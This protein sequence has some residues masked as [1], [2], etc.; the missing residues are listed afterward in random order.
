LA[1][2]AAASCSPIVGVANG[3]TEKLAAAQQD[4]SLCDGQRGDELVGGGRRTTPRH[5]TRNQ[6]VSDRRRVRQGD[7]RRIP[8][9]RLDLV[10]DLSRQRGRILSIER[11][12][13][14]L[15]TAASSGLSCRLTAA[16]TKMPPGQPGNAGRWP[17]TGYR[18]S[19]PGPAGLGSCASEA[20][21]IARRAMICT[22][23]DRE[24][25]VP[26]AA[27]GVGDTIFR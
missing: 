23:R 15:H 11:D 2:G 7:Q 8:V 3:G 25:R 22:I 18:R 21:V 17:A 16:A 4:A 24:S 19:A 13:C 20:A 26:W 6:V 14:G 10:E 1:V 12:L 5:E 9:L 27:R